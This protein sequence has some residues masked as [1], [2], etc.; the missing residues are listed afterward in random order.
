MPN[1]QCVLR[2]VANFFV[3]SIKN[4]FKKLSVTLQT[5]AAL[6]FSHSVSFVTKRGTGGIN[7]DISGNQRGL[8]GGRLVTKFK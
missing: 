1:D 5:A 2:V 4:Y 6:N 8:N 7:T 3:S